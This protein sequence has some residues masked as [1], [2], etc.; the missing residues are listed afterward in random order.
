MN[1]TFKVLLVALAIG[2]VLI[3]I[4][5]IFEKVRA[6]DA[7]RRTEEERLWNEPWGI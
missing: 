1:T 3:V 2:I 5:R 4:S 6:R 7:R